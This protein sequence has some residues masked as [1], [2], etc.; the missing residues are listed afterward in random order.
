[1]LH[2]RV[3]LPCGIKCF[4]FSRAI[5]FLHEEE[6]HTKE[7]LHENTKNAASKEVKTSQNCIGN[8]ETGLLLQMYKVKR[9]KTV[10]VPAEPGV[11]FKSRDKNKVRI[12]AR[13]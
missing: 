13:S 11:I 9:L 6:L 5:D 7:S 2:N 3:V 1:M 10:V 8:L 12:T 4:N